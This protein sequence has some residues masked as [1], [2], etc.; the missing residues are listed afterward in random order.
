MPVV[1]LCSNFA[2]YTTTLCLATRA[3][4]TGITDFPSKLVL[5]EH[6]FRVHEWIIQLHIMLCNFN[7]R[8]FFFVFFVFFSLS[9][10]LENEP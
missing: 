4:L 8:Q 2:M 6:Y 7:I 5:H 9:V 10:Y 3:L 1:C